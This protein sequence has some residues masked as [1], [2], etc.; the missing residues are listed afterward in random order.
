MCATYDI[1][2]IENMVS[3]MVIGVLM[4]EIPSLVSTVTITCSN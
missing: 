2:N 1:Q 3:Y 4:S